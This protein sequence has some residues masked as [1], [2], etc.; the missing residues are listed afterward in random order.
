MES[1]PTCRVEFSSMTVSRNRLAEDLASNR[2]EVD[3]NYEDRL[4]SLPGARCVSD[5]L[6][7]LNYLYHQQ[8]Q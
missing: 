7:K 2:F 8:Q 3:T 1:C 4:N 5:F 6:L